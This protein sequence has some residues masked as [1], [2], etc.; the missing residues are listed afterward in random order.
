MVSN[1]AKL[2]KT[3]DR[4]VKDV[5]QGLQRFLM[6]TAKVFKWYKW[7]VE[8]RK[9]MENGLRSQKPCAYNTN[10]NTKNG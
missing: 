4:N 6:S 1:T 10:A 3:V 9:K 8:N 5:A 2:K 7:Q